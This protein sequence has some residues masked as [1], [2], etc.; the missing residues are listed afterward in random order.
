MKSK[1]PLSLME[2]LVMVLVFALAAAL[3][4]QA[5]AAA[6]K[7]SR[8]GAARDQAV[9]L[10]QNA[11]EVYK[12]C[13]GDGEKAAELLGGEVSQGCWS[14]F[15]AADLTAVGTREEAAYEVDVLPENSGVAG[16]GRASVS[17]FENGGAEAVFRLSVAWQ[18]VDGNE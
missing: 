18:E 5:F 2:Q 15:Y 11:A 8:T 16:L 14:T 3:C 10:A 7:I 9:L 6:G 4:V 1:A 13:G 17:V 12:A